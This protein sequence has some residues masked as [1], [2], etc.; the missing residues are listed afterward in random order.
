MQDE[1]LLRQIVVHTLVPYQIL[2]VCICWLHRWH[3]QPARVRGLL[4]RAQN[5]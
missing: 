4:H 1:K 3:V 5:E 2:H